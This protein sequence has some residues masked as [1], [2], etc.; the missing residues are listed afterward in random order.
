MGIQ[1]NQVAVDAIDEAKRIQDIKDEAQARIISRL[2]SGSPDNFVIKQMNIMMLN[3]ELDDI[4]I[5][6]GTLTAE[7]GA[8]KAAFVKLKDEIKRIRSMSDDAE[9]NGDDVATFQAALDVAI[10]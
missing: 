7:Q 8:Q 1:V 6:G 4:V 9:A 10:L 2:P 3:A 5:N